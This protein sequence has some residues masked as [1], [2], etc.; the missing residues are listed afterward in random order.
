MVREE[1][2]G[3]DFDVVAS[4][5]ATQDAQNGFI[6]VTGGARTVGRDAEVFATLWPFFRRYELDELRRFE[7][8]LAL[9]LAGLTGD[10][11]P[12]SIFA[13]SPFGLV[14]LVVGT[15]SAWW[16]VVKTVSGEK[17]PIS[18][19]DLGLASSWV[20]AAAG[21]VGIGVVLWYTLKT[22]R[23]RA[24]VASLSSITRALA[25][26]VEMPDQIRNA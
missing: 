15:L 23:N 20:T 2:E 13:R 16:A 9:E 26:Y 11:H 7:R 1:H 19:S 5:G 18:L 4:S 24:Q 17:T 10:R 22:A 21:L 6:E 25:L 12:R 3:A 8:L 14:A